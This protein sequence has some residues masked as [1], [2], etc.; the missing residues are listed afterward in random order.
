[1]D[2]NGDLGIVSHHGGTFTENAGICPRIT[3]EKSLF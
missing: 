2:T 1:M 3:D